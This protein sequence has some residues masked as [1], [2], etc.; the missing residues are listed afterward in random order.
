MDSVL[1]KLREHE[2]SRGAVHTIGDTSS[3]TFDD[4]DWLC[5]TIAP[6]DDMNHISKSGME[7]PLSLHMWIR[8]EAPFSRLGT[9]CEV[10]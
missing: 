7:C 8:S 5:H 1:K 10:I 6:S 9:P 2:S 3:C 4:H